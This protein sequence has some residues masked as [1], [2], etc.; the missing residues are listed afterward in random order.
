MMAIVRVVIGE[1]F[2]A[3]GGAQQSG[4]VLE[5]KEAPFEHVEDV[6]GQMPLVAVLHHDD[7]ALAV[8]FVLQAS[9]FVD[10]LFI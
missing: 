8:S 7:V 9:S 6:R 3:G 5:R 10:G 4:L 2:A 1:R